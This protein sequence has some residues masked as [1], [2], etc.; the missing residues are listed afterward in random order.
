MRL[1]R[2]AKD[3]LRPAV[4]PFLLLSRRPGFAAVIGVAPGDGLP[5]TEAGG[6]FSVTSY[7]RILDAILVLKRSLDNAETFN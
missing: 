2:S 5:G 6:V 1:V 3:A 7:G 4:S